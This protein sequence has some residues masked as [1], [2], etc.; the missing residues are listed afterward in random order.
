MNDTIHNTH[1]NWNTG[2]RADIGNHDGGCLE[3]L[4]QH[5]QLAHAG[6]AQLQEGLGWV[7]RRHEL[8]AL[9]RGRARVIANG[10]RRDVHGDV[11]VVEVVLVRHADGTHLQL[12]Q[13]GVRVLGT[14]HDGGESVELEIDHHAGLVLE[15]QEVLVGQVD[16]PVRGLLVHE[17]ERRRDGAR[18]GHGG[19][20]PRSVLLKRGLVLAHRLQQRLVQS[21]GRVGPRVDRVVCQE[22]AALVG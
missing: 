5:T 21:V 4:I 6:E 8:A 16:H 18:V 22:D 12:H 3:H 19:H 14:E 13:L 20:E 17:R 9:L 11:H 10:E 1:D 15:Q 7:R 2:N